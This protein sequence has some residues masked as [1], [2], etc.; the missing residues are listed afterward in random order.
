MHADISHITWEFR[1]LISAS[2][3]AE[4]TH[5]IPVFWGVMLMGQNE[6]L[7]LQQEISG[8]GALNLGSLFF[9]QSSKQSLLFVIEE[10]ISSI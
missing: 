5:A 8:K 9:I 10:N 4:C 3:V 7:Y 6:Y 2:I 1:D